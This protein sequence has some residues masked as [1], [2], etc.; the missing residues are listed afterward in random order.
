MALKLKLT[1]EEHGKLDDGLKALYV[2]KD[3]GF[4]LDADLPQPEDVSGL[5]SALEKERTESRKAREALKAFEGIDVDAA[6]KA[7]QDQADAEQ[8]R[9]KAEGNFEA[10]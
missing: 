10:L 2:K 8:K 5:K 9:L 6:K 7:M 3:D 1:A 4:V